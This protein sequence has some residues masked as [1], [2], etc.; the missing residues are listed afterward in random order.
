MRSG[1]NLVVALG[2]NRDAFIGDSLGE[3]SRVLPLAVKEKP[4]TAA[5]LP[6][7]WKDGTR[8]GNQPLRP[9]KGAAAIELTKFAPRPAEENRSYFSLMDGPAEGGGSP[10]VAQ[11]RLGLGRVTCVATDLDAPPFGDYHRAAC[12]GRGC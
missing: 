7:P 9:A 12:T 1:G 11:G 8:F 3:L 2:G 4:Y 10:L 5:Q 6:L